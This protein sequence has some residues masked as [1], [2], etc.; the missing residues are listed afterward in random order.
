MSRI[1]LITLML[2]S[3][4]SYSFEKT[5][6][7]YA[8]LGGTAAEPKFVQIFIMGYE[9]VGGSW[10]GQSDTI[11]L[12][13]NTQFIPVALPLAL[14]TGY[15]LV[16]NNFPVGFQPEIWAKENFIDAYYAQGIQSVVACGSNQFHY[17]GH[18]IDLKSTIPVSAGDTAGLT[19]YYSEFYNEPPFSLYP[20]TSITQGSGDTAI[21]ALN[22]SVNGAFQSIQND[23]IKF[24][25][26]SGFSNQ[27][28]GIK[29][30]A[31]FVFDGFYNKFKIIHNL[32]SGSF[33]S[34]NAKMFFESYATPYTAGML[35]FIRDSL[36][37]SWWEARYRMR[38]T[39]TGATQYSAFGKPDVLAAINYSGSIPADPYDVLG[40]VGN[41]HS[42]RV[43]NE[44]RLT[45]DSVGNASSYFVYDR[46]VLLGTYSAHGEL[47]YSID[48]NSRKYPHEFWYRAMRHTQETT[49]SKKINVPFYKY[50]KLLIK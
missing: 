19:A 8:L 20:I 50:S 3:S 11:T 7:M 28:S 34:G 5:K 32:G 18:P 15:N 17:F 25:G 14:S 29:Q 39:A 30:N 2:I 41:I 12:S 26:V 4:I 43:G 22:V 10:T 13:S 48:R 1:I 31:A 33:S 23:V 35:A 24:I 47:T 45:I 46:S 42:V 9:S 38:V 21:V 27:L 36:Q 40:P 6:V 16:V 49:E 37:C 44:V